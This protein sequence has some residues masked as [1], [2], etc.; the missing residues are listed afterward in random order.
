MNTISRRGILFAVPSA[1]AIPALAGTPSRA[2][3]NTGSAPYQGFPSQDP[4]LVEAS[5]GIQG[6]CGPHSLSLLH[7]ARHEGEG[8]IHHVLSESPDIPEFL[9]D[10]PRVSASRGVASHGP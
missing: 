2:L 6:L 4:A 7:H 3:L 5:P 10:T 9:G 1:L 8:C